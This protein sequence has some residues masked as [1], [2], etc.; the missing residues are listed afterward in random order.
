MPWTEEF[1]N[2]GADVCGCILYK[3]QALLLIR[4][5]ITDARLGLFDL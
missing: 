3:Q 5:W 4:L 1:E 2:P